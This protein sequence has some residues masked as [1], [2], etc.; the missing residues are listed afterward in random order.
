MR[1][2][3]LC[4]LK[5]SLLCFQSPSTRHPKSR[6][7]V[8]GVAKRVDGNAL[9]GNLLVTVGDLHVPTAD[10]V[11]KFSW[12]KKN[13]KDFTHALKES[14]QQ[15]GQNDC[16]EKRKANHSERTMKKLRHRKMAMDCCGCKRVMEYCGCKRVMEYCANYRAAVGLFVG[17]GCERSEL[18]CLSFGGEGARPKVLVCFPL[19]HG[20]L[21]GKARLKSRRMPI[22][23][24]LSLVPLHASKANGNQDNH[25]PSTA[26]ITTNLKKDQGLRPS[27]L[28]P[29]SRQG[30]SLRSQPCPLKEPTA[31]RLQAQ[32]SMTRLHALHSMTF[33]LQLI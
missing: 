1:R 27:F 24:P 10:F 5:R 18:P 15:I 32:H 26:T 8:T 30:S 6:F 29:R 22:I 12:K 16:M 11:V 28:S 33:F 2:G 4:K 17:Q 21:R 13:R 9:L 14:K 7:V 20:S 23:S 31:R 19:N 25:P 3:D